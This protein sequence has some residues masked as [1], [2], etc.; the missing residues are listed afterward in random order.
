MAQC[1]SEIEMAGVKEKR[2]PL[3]LVAIWCWKP[4]LM[5]QR[6][7]NQQMLEESGRRIPPLPVEET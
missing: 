3:N 4:F 7:V 6:T 2:H 1:E 5:H